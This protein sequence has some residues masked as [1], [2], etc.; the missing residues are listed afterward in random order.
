ML[1]YS[2]SKMYDTEK[3]PKIANFDDSDDL[4][5]TIAIINSVEIDE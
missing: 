3:T 2:N 1:N 4:F 5:K